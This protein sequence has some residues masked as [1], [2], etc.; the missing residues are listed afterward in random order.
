MN[1][2]RKFCDWLSP[3]EPWERTAALLALVGFAAIYFS[4]HLIAAVTAGRIPLVVGG[5][6]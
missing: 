1:R 4:G 5:A 6:P 3:N 2:V